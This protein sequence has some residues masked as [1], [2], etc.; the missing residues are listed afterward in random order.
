MTLKEL[1]VPGRREESLAPELAEWKQVQL[2]T[3]L[4][5]MQRLPSEEAVC[6]KMIQEAEDRVKQLEAEKKFRG[7]IDMMALLQ[8]TRTGPAPRW[9]VYNPM[10]ACDTIQWTHEKSVTFEFLRAGHK[11]GQLQMHG[12]NVLRGKRAYTASPILLPTRVR[13]QVRA[14]HRQ[15]IPSYIL[16]EPRVVDSHAIPEPD[17]AL[18]VEVA[19]AWFVVDLW[20]DPAVEDPRALNTL[21]EFYVNTATPFPYK[22]AT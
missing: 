21:R 22:K 5:R 13:E 10:L 12:P 6:R 1:I 2:S 4:L 16:F 3:D 8:Q 18:I 19:G 17:P 20:D 11:V 15:N 14:L 9:F 7:R